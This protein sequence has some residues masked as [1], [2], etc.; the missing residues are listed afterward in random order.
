MV[1]FSGKMRIGQQTMGGFPIY[2]RQ[3]RVSKI[4]YFL[5]YLC[6]SMADVN[7]FYLT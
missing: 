2:S 1:R 5:L 3:A 7:K 4:K 6:Q